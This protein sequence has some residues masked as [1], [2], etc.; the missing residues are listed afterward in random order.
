MMKQYGMIPAA[1]KTD[2][3]NDIIWTTKFR[4]NMK[5]KLNE[6]LSFAGRASVYKVWSQGSNIRFYNGRAGDMYLDGNTASLPNGDT[7]HLERAYFLYRFGPVD[8]PMQFSLGRRPSTNGPP[9]EYRDYNLEG[10]SPLGT[11][12]NWQ[13]DGASYNFG[14]EEKTGIPGAALKLCY[15]VGFEGGYGNSSS[16]NNNAMVDDVHM[17]GLI[18]TFYDDD[19]TSVVMNYAHAWGVTDGFTGLT[20]MPFIAYREDSNGDG[21]EEYYFE[22]NH[23]GFVSRLEPTTDLGDWDAVSLLYRRK[24]GFGKVFLSANWSHTTPDKISQ[25]PYYELMGEGLL[26]SDGNLQSRDGYMLYAGAQFDVPFTKGVLGLEYNY[27]SKYWFNFTG[28]EDS[29]VASKLAARGHVFEGYYIQPIFEKNFF[30]KVGAQFYDYEYT[31]SGSQMGEPVDIDQANGL[32]A[33]FPIADEVMVFYM[34][35]T[36]RF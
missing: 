19:E 6:S 16:F 2:V 20:V 25:N 30:F 4:L 21:V 28:A 17:A 18:A 7:I 35:A 26:S 13:F 3:D 31:G 11:I 12:I 24:F 15:G 9:L 1:E 10:G 27:G 32:D 34:N 23:G 29:L 14:L 5:A 8:L 22:Q 33:V 36:A